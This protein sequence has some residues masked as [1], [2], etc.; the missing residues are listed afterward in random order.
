M[1]SA[2]SAISPV[3]TSPSAC[4]RFFTAMVWMTVAIKRMK[5]TAVSEALAAT[6]GTRAKITSG[7][8]SETAHTQRKG[9]REN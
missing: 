7:E 9:K 5:T 2:P 1:S 8:V 6:A 4:L 3:G